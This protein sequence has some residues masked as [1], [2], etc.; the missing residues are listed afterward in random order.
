[1]VVQSQVGEGS[2]MLIDPHHTPIILQSS[3]SQQKK[4]HKSRKPK[5]K[6]IKVPHPSDPMEHVADEVVHKELGDSLVRAATAASSLEAGQC[7]GDRMKLNE[8]MEL[9]TNLQT[10]FIDLKKTKITQA[11]E[12]DS[13]K[14]K[15]KKLERINKSR[16]HKLKRLYKVGLTARVKSLDNEKSLGED[17]SKQGRRINDI[18]ADEDITLVNVKADAE[19]FDADKGLGGEEVFVEQEVVADKEK[20]NEVTLAQALA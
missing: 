13:L 19:M 8:M 15:V 11:N 16:A 5:R 4:T 9:C 17:A 18:D 10:R 2:T 3:S 12:I 6:V 14:M 7:D 20:I 1:M